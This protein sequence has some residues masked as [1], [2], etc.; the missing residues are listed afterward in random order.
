VDVLVLTH[1]FPRFAGDAAGSFILGLAKALA[2]DGV[3]LT[4]IAPHAPGVAERETFDGI[5]VR[6]FRYAPE[7]FETL[8]YTGTMAEQVRSSW[9][10]RAAMATLLARAVYATDRARRERAP[11]VIHAHW[12]FPSGLA[13]AAVSRI[14]RVPLVTTLHGSDV[15]LAHE[16]RAARPVY[17]RV[18]AQSSAVTAVSTW[19]AERAR[20]LAPQIAQPTVAPMP[21]NVELFSPDGTREADRLLFVGRLS[22][23]KGLE[24]L[25]RALPELPT[26][27]TL[28]VVGDGPERDRLRGLCDS[29]GVGARVRWHPPTSQQNLAHFYRRA[30]ALVVPSV[31]EGLGLVAVEAHLCGTPVV[32]F[33]SGG[34]GDVVVDGQ[35]GILAA[36]VGAAPLASALREL[37]ERPD[38]GASLGR[39]GRARAL[40][41]F[42]PN[43]VARRYVA[44]YQ[45]AI[46]HFHSRRG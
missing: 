7:R 11:A 13:A 46:S 23:Q 2:D 45:E 36:P 18:A 42:A 26:P 27:I 8:A 35:T 31:G 20:A 16:F 5:A 43:A 3:S 32:A 10:G 33:D 4:V 44:I 38:A 30:T 1:A 21:A 9:T 28:D 19:L 25:L 22:L 41:R 15:R 24:L 37:L 12:W 29:L 34:I 14:R 6:R 39:E 17:A 40:A